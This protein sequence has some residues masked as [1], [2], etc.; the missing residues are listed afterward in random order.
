MRKEISRKLGVIFIPI[1][2]FIVMKFLWFSYRKKYHFI[3]DPIEE[4]CLA[5]TW[6]SELLISPQVYKKLRK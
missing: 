1:L 6:H 2:I 5:V 4:Q 3:D